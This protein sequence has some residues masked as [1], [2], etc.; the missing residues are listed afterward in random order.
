[1]SQLSQKILAKIHSQKII[2]RSKWRFIGL[3]AVLWICFFI[4][5]TIGII[6]V[7][8][9]FLEMG[10]P[11]RPYMEW[12]PLPGPM[13][14]LPYL[15]FL[16]GFGSIVCVIIAYFVFYKTEKGYR[17]STVWI[18]GML[19]LGSFTGGY[20]LHRT[21]INSLGEKQMQRLVPPYGRMRA[22]FQ[23]GMPLPE[24][25]LLPGKI[26]SITDDGYTIKSPDKKIWKV[27]L[28]CKNEECKETQKNLKKGQPMLFMGEIKEN[29]T[30]DKEKVFEATDINS[31]PQKGCKKN[32][33]D[34]SCG[35]AF[36]PP[37]PPSGENRE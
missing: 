19:I 36:M 13:R 21:K 14:V 12:M 26:E 11:E 3:H 37:T 5:L 33:K 2:P 28:N 27:S 6:G 35:R 23:K 25:G 18:V 15:P 9:I 24:L 34:A 17:V 30:E 31:P 32:K 22:D 4:T 10:M 29:D 7:S 1:M 20:A 8:L 16:W